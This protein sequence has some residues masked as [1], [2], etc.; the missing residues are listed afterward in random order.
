MDRFYDG[1]ALRGEGLKVLVEERSTNCGMN[2]VE[3]KRVLDENGIYNPEKIV[4]YQDCTMSLRTKAGFERVYEGTGTQVSC[5]T[6]WT[7]VVTTNKSGEIVYDVEKI[8]KE[9]GNEIKE[10][11][12]WDIE[13]FLGLIVGEIPRFEAYGP[14]GIGSIVNVVI[15]G[16]IRSAWERL[17]TEGIGKRR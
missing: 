8:R 17:E 14:R 4:L 15:P 11:E 2:A 16:D 13:R 3:T 10:E 12:L 1:E 6:G 9:T 5:W 7:P